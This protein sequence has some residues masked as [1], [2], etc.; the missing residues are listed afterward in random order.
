[1]T[2]EVTPAR[3]RFALVSP[4][5]LQPRIARIRIGT[6]MDETVPYPYPIRI[7]PIRCYPPTKIQV[8]LRIWHDF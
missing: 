5:A 4:R 7:Y 2:G 8:G 3:V 1:M 6:G